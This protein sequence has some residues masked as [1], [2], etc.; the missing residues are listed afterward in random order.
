MATNFTAIVSQ[1]QHFGDEQG[2]FNNVEP[3]LNVIT[4]KDFTF[5]CPNVNPSE[6][7]FLMFQSRDVDHQ[8]NIFTVNKV[9]V[10]GGLPASPSRDTWNGNIMLIGS[11]HV[12]KATN[13]TLHVESR[14]E[15]GESGGDIDDFIIDNVVIMYKTR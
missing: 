3:N 10:S 7:A 9:D 1:R 12:L 4:K 6:T 13:N 15:K 2:T 5:D 14:N 8:R 11:H